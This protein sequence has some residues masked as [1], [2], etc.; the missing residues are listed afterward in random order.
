MSQ[1]SDL[2]GMAWLERKIVLVKNRAQGQEQWMLEDELCTGKLRG[3][4]KQWSAYLKGTVWHM[5]P[6]DPSKAES[7]V[8]ALNEWTKE[9]LDNNL[10][11]W[12]GDKSYTEL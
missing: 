8:P 2:T 12:D 10:T 3:T 7:W 1:Q 5:M 9:T 6:E 11:P 4:R